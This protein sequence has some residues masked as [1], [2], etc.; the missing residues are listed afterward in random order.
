MF[1]FLPSLHGDSIGTAVF[2]E[3]DSLRKKEGGSINHSSVKLTRL[4][5]E[6]LVQV[7]AVLQ[8]RSVTTIGPVIH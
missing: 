7:A 8:S 3:R 4:S 5:S 1:L 6:A 2:I